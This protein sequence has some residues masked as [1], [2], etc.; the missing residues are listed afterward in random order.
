MLQSSADSSKLQLP[1]TKWLPILC[2]TQL[3]ILPYPSY[4]LSQMKVSECFILSRGYQVGRES[5]VAFEESVADS[6]SP[7]TCPSLPSSI[8]YFAF[9][10][11]PTS[12]LSSF[13]QI[14]PLWVLG[15]LSKCLCRLLQFTSQVASV[16]VSTAASRHFFSK[17]QQL[18]IAQSF[19]GV[20]P[21]GR[22][23]VCTRRSSIC[24]ETWEIYYS[25]V[26]DLCYLKVHLPCF[27]LRH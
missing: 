26:L 25:Y 21:T 11:H 6:F 10:R 17:S 12:T 19:R 20:S 3:A 1:N 2:L 8:P 4:W 27:L 22:F 9:Q 7:T 23:Q 13:L 14:A 16:T 5:T 24:W 18:G 15:R